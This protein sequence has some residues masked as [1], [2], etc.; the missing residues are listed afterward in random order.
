[1]LLSE[2]I[3]AELGWRDLV[4]SRLGRRLAGIIFLSIIAIEGIV[5]VP[6]YFNQH[7]IYRTEAIRIGQV[8]SDALANLAA[9]DS[10][11]WTV[12]QPGQ[13]FSS[14][15]EIVG[16]AIC[17]PGG[18]CTVQF[19][20]SIGDTEAIPE[21]DGNYA[22]P[23]ADRLKTVRTVETSSGTYRIVVVVDTAWTTEAL[24]KDLLHVAILV[25]CI[26]IIFALI[27]VVC[28]GKI[29]LFPLMQLSRNL[30]AALEHPDRPN[31]FVISHDRNDEI[32]RLLDR[33]NTI[34][35]D[36]AMREA[37]RREA[38][39]HALWLARFPEEDPSPIIRLSDTGRVLYANETAEKLVQAL[40]VGDARRSL[41]ASIEMAQEKQ[42]PITLTRQ[43]GT[44][45]YRLLLVPIKGE[46]Y[47]NI[48]ASDITEMVRARDDLAKS[49]TALEDAVVQRTAE[50]QTIQQRLTDAIESMDDGFAY[51][52]PDGRLALYNQ[53]Y[54]QVYEGSEQIIKTGSTLE[55]ILRYGMEHGWYP[56][57]EKDPEAWLQ[58]RLAIRREATGQPWI[59]RA[60]SGRYYRIRDYRTKD[61]GSVTV[62]V[63]VTDQMRQAEEFALAKEAAEGASRAKSEFLATMS[64]EIRTPMNGVMGMANLLLDSNLNPQ[65]KSMTRTILDSANGLLTV[66][67]DILDFS[68]IESGKI[69]LEDAEFRLADS[70]ESA[71]ELL[72]SRALEKNLVLGSIIDP[73]MPERLMGDEGRLR[74]VIINLAGNGVKFTQYG[75]VTIE[76]R[77]VGQE[78]DKTRIRVSVH[79]TGPGIPE[80]MFDKL[81]SDFSQLDASRSRAHEGTGLG[82]AI[83][84]RLIE[85]MGGEIGVDSADEE[86]STFWFEVPLA[87]LEGPKYAENEAIPALNI[88]IHAGDVRTGEVLQRQI[89]AWGATAEI[90]G[91]KHRLDA[92][93]PRGFDA[94]IVDAEYLEAFRTAREFALLQAHGTA[95]IVLSSN[96]FSSPDIR[97]DATVLKPVRQSDLLNAIMHLH[98]DKSGNRREARSEHRREEEQSIREKSQG[99]APSR[100]LVAEDN[101]VNQQVI[102]MMLTKMG[103]TIDVAGNGVEAVSLARQAPYDLILMDVHMPEQ[104]GFS[105]T[106]EIRSLGGKLETIPIIALT[107]N[108]EAGVEQQCF[109]SGM[110]GYVTKPVR[111]QSLADILREQI[112]QG[113]NTS[114]RERFVT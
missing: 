108:V 8:A 93:L 2:G 81:F 56:G 89:T 87:V 24:L 27:A 51:F 14:A 111:V 26:G 106:Q 67:N 17:K 104:D 45:V 4:G 92:G 25:A 102:R 73:A 75:S 60:K 18:D 12:V 15:E 53:R 3:K 33:Y 77:V 69:E 10:G 82:L 90:L 28:V 85:F 9:V 48:Y 30:S 112:P 5:L 34:L 68:K 29:V 21:K 76:A 84:R 101:P 58:N 80:D 54:A 19:G 83:S 97:P 20:E 44:T 100:I 114:H 47:L 23:E 35:Q 36:N 95:V 71:V 7:A 61:G 39:S 41:L 1:M 99:I 105:A 86:G 42:G 65:Q 57:S 107:A 59:T 110:T 50:L 63:D 52:G 88:L 49:K 62:R 74:Q 40:V 66:I 98:D 31:D 78:N 13:K 37:N 16:G 109:D 96:E 94:V 11:G 22:Q 79:D 38:E 6:S 64:H 103:H 91:E 46:K 55:E 113:D 70:I 72:Q 32:G 43:V